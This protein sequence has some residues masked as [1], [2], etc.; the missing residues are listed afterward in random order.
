MGLLCGDF[1]AMSLSA[2]W[3]SRTHWELEAAQA[4]SAV[5]DAVMMQGGTRMND[6]LR[7]MWSTLH[8]SPGLEA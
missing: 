1:C 6:G 3:L 7:C 8:R 2:L 5:Q 4:H